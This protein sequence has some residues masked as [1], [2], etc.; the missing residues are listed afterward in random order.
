[1]V[2]VPDAARAELAIANLNHK[3]IKGQ[4]VVVSRKRPHSDHH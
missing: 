4:A 3:V 1:M 2:E